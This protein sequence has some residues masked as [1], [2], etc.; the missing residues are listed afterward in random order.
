MENWISTRKFV[1]NSYTEQDRYSI[2]CQYEVAYEGLTFHL[3]QTL[4]MTLN[5]LDTCILF[6]GHYLA[7]GTP[8]SENSLLYEP[9]VAEHVY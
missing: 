1:N 7:N 8:D 9:G 2:E 3:V 5:D 4:M 6:H